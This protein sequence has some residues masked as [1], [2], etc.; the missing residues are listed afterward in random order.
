MDKL[1]QIAIE[2]IQEQFLETLQTNPT[3]RAMVEDEFNG[4]FPNGVRY[5]DNDEIVCMCQIL[6]YRRILEGVL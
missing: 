1:R 5:Q 4:R 2:T 3:V 6:V